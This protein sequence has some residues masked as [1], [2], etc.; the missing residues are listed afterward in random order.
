MHCGSCGS[1]ACMS[2]PEQSPSLPAATRFD[3]SGLYTCA[4]TSAV[5]DPLTTAEN[6]I[7]SGNTT[8]WWQRSSLLKAVR[9]DMNLACEDNHGGLLE[10][11]DAFKKCE[12]NDP[13]DFFFLAIVI[14][15]AFRKKSSFLIPPKSFPAPGNLDMSYP[16]GISLESMLMFL[17]C[18]YLRNPRL[19][20][21]DTSLDCNT[22]F[23]SPFLLHLWPYRA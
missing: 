5:C 1:L 18:L 20:F 2:L 23:S 17:K 22:S 8:Y 15:Y 19:S 14:Q 4:A 10:K 21:T 12:R 7:F 6:S 13:V 11:S 3:F 16:Y 9:T